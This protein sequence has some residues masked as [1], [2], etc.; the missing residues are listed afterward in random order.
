MDE[1]PTRTPPRVAHAPWWELVRVFLTL[2]ALSP[3]GPGLTGV[4]QTEIQEKRGWL[5]QARFVEGVALVNML[6]GPG[7]AQLS[8]FL[9]YL[10]AGWWGGLLAGSCFLLPSFVVMLTLT[11][12]YTHY[13][14]LP[15]LRGVFNGLNPVVV[16]IFAV[17]VYRLSTAAITDVPQGMLALAAALALGLTPV[18][19]V[20]LL[21]L[22]G[23]LGV[24]WYG[25][26]PWGL[27]ATTGVAVLQGLFVWS[28][29]WLP[30]P[31]L[32]AWASSSGAS[33][34]PPGLGQIGLFFA[35][36]GL[37]TFGGGLVLLAFLQDQVVQHLQW[38]SPQEFL[39]GLALGRLTPGPIPMLAAFIGYKVAGLGGA[40]VAGVAIF[41]PSFVLMLS[42]LPMLAHLERVAWLNA[43]RQG[44]SPAII[45]MIAVTLLKLVPTAVPGLFP[46]VLA[47]ATVGAMVGWRVGPVPLMA[48][49]AAL[50]VLGRL[51]GTG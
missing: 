37:F 30:L 20:P 49:G 6:P 33:L 11:L 24:A 34:H 15:G 12:L 51:W 25:S 42:L 48:V 47:L 26:R 50:G 16:G 19:I 23:A 28:P 14:A 5:S 13:G 22:A 18:G 39:D 43:A 9:G 41:V 31:A 46:A 7:G 17:A 1:T 4:L 29:R 32:P 45:G 36:V 10:R 2:G 8:I 3:S 35:K 27:V 40:V 44:M 38:L 21:L